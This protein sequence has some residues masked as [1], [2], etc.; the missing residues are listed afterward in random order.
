MSIRKKVFS[1]VGNRLRHAAGIYDERNALYGDNYKNFGIVMIG[2]F[3]RGIELKT[4]DDFTR[5]GL[6]V[7]AVSKDTRYAQQFDK[8]GHI[9]SLDD[10]VVYRTML[11]EVDHEIAARM[12]EDAL[13]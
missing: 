4:A 9:D 11:N 5:F 2:M 6:L 7:Q 13:K 10:G 3:P 1:W 8:G 12:A